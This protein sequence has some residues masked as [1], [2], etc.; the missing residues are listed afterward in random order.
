MGYVEDLKYFTWKGAREVVQ[1]K[2]LPED[3]I[4]LSAT[5]VPGD[6]APS[7]GLHGHCMYGVHTLVLAGKTPPTLKIPVS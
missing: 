5:L 6:L 4:L 1:P 7:S 3:G 2:S